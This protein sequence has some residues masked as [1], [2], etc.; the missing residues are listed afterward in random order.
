MSRA[1]FATMRGPFRDEAFKSMARIDIQRD[2]H[3]DAA[4][5]RAVVDK[6]AARLGE[7]FGTTSR[8]EGDTLRFERSGVKG[9]I[10]LEPALVRVQAE[11]GMLL[12]PMKGMI[13]QEIRQKL[14]QY[15]A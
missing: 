1:A 11:L 3:L 9:G 7:K 13:E 2:H 5:A 4:Q 12:S 14:D 15:F 6:V 8:W 10:T